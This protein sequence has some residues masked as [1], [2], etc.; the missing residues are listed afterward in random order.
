MG[1]NQTLNPLL[2]KQRAVVQDL[3]QHV[4]EL[5]ELLEQTTT[6]RDEAAADAI[7]NGKE[8][9]LELERKDQALFNVEGEI[10]IAQD[11]LSQANQVLHVLETA[12]KRRG[13]AGQPAKAKAIETIIQEKK[14]EVE[15]LTTAAQEI[16]EKLTDDFEN[17]ELQTEL[18]VIEERQQAAKDSL[19]LYEQVH[20]SAQKEDQANL[21]ATRVLE[22]MTMRDEAVDLAQKRIKIAEK[23][24]AYFE[25]LAP[26]MREWRE[27]D[28]GVSEAVGAAFRL[29][30]KGAT[31]REREHAAQA[32]WRAAQVN[33]IATPVAEAL[34]RANVQDITRDQLVFKYTTYG[35]AQKEPITAKES[36][37][38]A[39]QLLIG[40]LDDGLRNHVVR[41]ER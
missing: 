23:I 30:T 38:K 35:Q 15:S 40:S 3:T 18:Q 41:H 22:A 26:L 19:K 24:D 2:T 21:D 25:G 33:S 27:T 5:Q 28:Q 1:D 16:I 29:L 17:V 39:L 34:C 13:N 37:D 10:S 7:A 20:A 14:A 11:R 8:R 31:F 36:A 32:A 6:E 12:H 4:E 9:T